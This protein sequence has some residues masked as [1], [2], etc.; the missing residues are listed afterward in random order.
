MCKNTMATNEL[1]FLKICI[2]LLTLDDLNEN[3][4]GTYPEVQL[5]QSNHSD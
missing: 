1:V 3:G 2:P 4:E 5:V